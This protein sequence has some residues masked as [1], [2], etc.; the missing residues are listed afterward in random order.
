MSNIYII[1]SFPGTAGLLIYKMIAVNHRTSGL[2]IEE[3]T[4]YS[5]KTE[6][7]ETV[8]SEW[9]YNNWEINTS[10]TAT[11]V[12]NISHLPDY[13][14]LTSQYPDAKLITV[15]HDV[16]ECDKIATN[17]L[18]SYYANSWELPEVQ[19]QFRRIIAEF[20][21]FF[22]NQAVTPLEF[23]KKERDTFLRILANQVLLGG[24]H[25]IEVPTTNPNIYKIELNDILNHPAKF[26]SQMVEILGRPLTNETLADYKGVQ[27]NI[28]K[29]FFIG[30]TK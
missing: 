8:T 10:T 30:Y 1:N 3:E 2:P 5:F 21:Q 19:N 11:V 29:S 23:T 26:K 9:F 20:P 24:F 13:D 16:N 7:P 22:S 14:L 17:T 6:K 25:N 27:M 12:C 4:A 18:I 15:T 28:F